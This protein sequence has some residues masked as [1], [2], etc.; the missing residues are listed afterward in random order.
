MASLQELRRD[1]EM[2]A[3]LQLLRE[4]LVDKLQLALSEMAGNILQ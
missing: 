4:D 2:V 3:E 1:A